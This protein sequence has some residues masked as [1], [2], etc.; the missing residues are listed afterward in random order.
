MTLYRKIERMIL[1]DA[2][3]VPLF[4]PMSALAVQAS[5]RGMQVTP[6]GVGNI[7]MERIWIAEPEESPRREDAS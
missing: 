4:H 7:A 3:I 5:I 6:M 2:P 1:E